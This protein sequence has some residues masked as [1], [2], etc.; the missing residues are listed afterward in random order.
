[1]FAKEEISALAKLYDD[2]E[3]VQLESSLT[4]EDLGTISQEADHLFN[5]IKRKH[6][7]S[8]AVRNLHNRMIAPRDTHRLCT[9]TMQRLHSN[10]EDSMTFDEWLNVI[11][12]TILYNDDIEIKVG[13]SFISWKP[14]TNDRTYL[15]SAKP[16]APFKFIVSSEEEFKEAITSSR[17]GSMTH[18]ELLNKTFVS[19]LSDNPFSKSGF[20]P[21]KIVCSYVYITK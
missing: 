21:L 19:T 15:F 7:E 4:E 16:L 3:K 9:I 1:M 10:S 20:C 14:I 18:S 12:E 11:A 6:G 8:M 5:K 17:I 13:F 2:I